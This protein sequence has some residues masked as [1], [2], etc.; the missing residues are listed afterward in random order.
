MKKKAVK[1]MTKD[2]VD[3]NMKTAKAP[4]ANNEKRKP[5]KAKMKRGC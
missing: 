4:L 5:V 3:K 2:S 1:K